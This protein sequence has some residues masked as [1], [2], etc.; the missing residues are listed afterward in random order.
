MVVL[1]FPDP[2]KTVKNAI[3]P[4]IIITYTDCTYV[5]Q[6]MQELQDI[7]KEDV[8]G[9]G[10]KSNEGKKP[11][12]EDE[13]IGADSGSRAADVEEFVSESYLASSKDIA[14]ADE[15]MKKLGVSGMR[16]VAII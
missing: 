13:A 3:W 2:N 6:H 7:D 16:R 15:S 12:I 1:I 14:E 9:S 4:E 8:V 5:F 11:D 10:D